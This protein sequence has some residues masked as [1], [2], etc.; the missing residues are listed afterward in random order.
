LLERIESEFPLVE[1]VE[2]GVSC[3][4][5]SALCS[6]YINIAET[7]IALETG[8]VEFV[9]GFAISP[10]E[11]TV[12]EFGAFV[13][14]AGYRTTSERQGMSDHVFNEPSLLGISA[15]MKL[16]W[17]ARYVSFEDAHAYCNW[18][19]C[20]LPSEV[21][22]IAACL[23]QTTVVEEYDESIQKRVQEL[24]HR[25]KIATLS[26][27]SIT[28]TVE[29]GLVV[30]RCG[31]RYVLCRGWEKEVLRNRRVVTKEFYDSSSVFHVCKL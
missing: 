25:R 30:A 12:A 11:I 23:A 14:A 9:P 1:R 21:E 15:T 20:R 8:V 24:L 29:A 27:S 13:Q 22:L 17:P 5:D 6:E 4:N 7:R 26:G 2:L 10:K 18:S 28:S 19:G 3:D 31:P 16:R